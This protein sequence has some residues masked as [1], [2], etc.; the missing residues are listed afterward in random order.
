M[1]ML[2]FVLALCGLLS[3]GGAQAQIALPFPGPGA[4]SV[5]C[6]NT[7]CTNWIA[8]VT[9]A[10]GTVSATQQGRVDTLITCL[11]TAG[12]GNLWTTL[13][14]M[15]LF[16]S[17]NVTQ[18]KYDITGATGANLALT[19]VGSPTFASSQGYAPGT[20]ASDYLNLNY[21]PSSAA[22]HLSLNSA[23]IGQYTRTAQTSRYITQGVSDGPNALFAENFRGVSQ[24]TDGINDGGVALNVSGYTVG[25]AGL[26]VFS[27]TASNLVT[28]YFNGV[29][30]GTAATASVGLSTKS[31]YSLAFNAN[32]TPAG[33]G[34]TPQVAVQFMAS[35]WNATNASDFS[36]C[37]NG[38]YMT[39]LGTNVY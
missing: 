28:F 24:V 15:W 33:G 3:L 22:V 38:G 36:T 4:A 12:G 35:G 20:P 26:H 34:T 25:A 32:G 30:R 14:A 27:R 37:I 9:G 19:V 10:G 31:F 7:E 39:S 2:R 11:K 29:S 13:D 16:A 1:R 17:E 8:A 23:A 18:A 5:G 21:I 6:V